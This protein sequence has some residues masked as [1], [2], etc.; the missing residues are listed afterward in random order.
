MQIGV[1]IDGMMDTTV[2]DN[3]LTLSHIS[4]GSCPKDDYA[5]EKSGGYASGTFSPAPTDVNFDGCV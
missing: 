3:T 2:T 1:G 4:A 5:Y